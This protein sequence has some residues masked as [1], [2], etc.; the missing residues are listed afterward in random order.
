MEGELPETREVL[1]EHLKAKV[2][3]F[4]QPLAD[5]ITDMLVAERSNSEIIEL[6]TSDSLL[7]KKVEKAVTSLYVPDTEVR[8]TLGVMLFQEVSEIEQELCA[9]VT[10]MLLE[11]PVSSLTQLLKNQEALKEAVMKAKREYLKF[12]TEEEI[13]KSEEVPP[14]TKSISKEK[15]ELGEIIY[16]KLLTSYPTEAS[17]LT[18]MLLQM[19]YRDLLRVIAEPKH[20]SEKVEL[21][22]R[23]LQGEGSRKN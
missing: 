8:E 22:L 2:R 17:K 23:V 5:Q 3:Y 16:E 18:G 15:Q 12:I 14:G 4:N 6:L 7:E 10:G 11:L 19:E 20:L 1:S 13:Q 9:Q 21:A